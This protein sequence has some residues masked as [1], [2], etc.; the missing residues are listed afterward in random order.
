M[1]PRFAGPWQAA[2]ASPGLTSMPKSQRRSSLIPAMLETL[3][4]PGDSPRRQSIQTFGDSPRRQS[5]QAPLSAREPAQTPRG[6]VGKKTGGPASA[7]ASTRR[8]SGSLEPDPAACQIAGVGPTILRVPSVFYIETRNERG[9]PCELE[10]GTAYRVVF[11]GP[12]LPVST[13]TELGGG[14]CSMQ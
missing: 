10:P 13:M 4:T 5:I 3:P 11:R 12:E 2:M 8:G 14:R 1:T 6:V 9:L 7:R